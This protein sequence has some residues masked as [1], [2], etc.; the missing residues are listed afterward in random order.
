MRILS[1]LEPI[2]GSIPRIKTYVL[3]TIQLC[4]YLSEHYRFV[5]D[6]AGTDD[7][8][9]SDIPLGIICCLAISL[10]QR[11]CQVQASSFIIPLYHWIQLFSHLPQSSGFLH[12]NIKSLVPF[13][14]IYIF[15]SSF[16][17]DKLRLEVSPSG[18]WSH[19]FMTNRWGNNDRLYFGGLQNHCWWWLQP[20][21]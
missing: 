15:F 17:S 18:V 9:I 1:P 12:G 3:Q 2:M 13:F 14:C 6:V 10:P 16:S 11:L 21:N 4:K 8:H 5:E 19:H 7:G 20:W